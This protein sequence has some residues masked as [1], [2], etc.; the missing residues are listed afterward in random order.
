MVRTVPDGIQ[1]MGMFGS[2]S[3]NVAVSNPDEVT[4]FLKLPNPFSRTMALG[5]TQP[6]NRNEYQESSWVF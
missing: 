6:F 2:T 4:G 1:P 3:R 5:S